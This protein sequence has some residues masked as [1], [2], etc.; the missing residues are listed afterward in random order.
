IPLDQLCIEQ[1]TTKIAVITAGGDHIEAL[2]TQLGFTYQS[3]L[4]DPASWST[5]AGP[6]LADL[7]RLKQYDLI[8]INCSTAKSSSSS[9]IDLGPN[10]ALIEQ[11][12]YDYVSQGGSIYSS[13]WAFLFP[14][15][16]FPGK[17]GFSLN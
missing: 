4:G 6:F 2:L 14:A 11:N 12:L 17:L 15:M 5:S 1:K 3:Y 10:A 9:S 7:T 16:A 8:F 13:D